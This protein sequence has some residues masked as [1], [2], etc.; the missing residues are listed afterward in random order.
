MPSSRPF[1]SSP[2][3]QQ[4]LAKE[5]ATSLI[6]GHR[7][8]FSDAAS[9]DGVLHLLPPELY[10]LMAAFL[11]AVS[12]AR[13]CLAWPALARLLKEEPHRSAQWRRRA[14]ELTVLP[15]PPAVHPCVMP[16]LTRCIAPHRPTHGMMR[17]SLT[18]FHSRP[19]SNLSSLHPHQPRRPCPIPAIPPSP[20]RMMSSTRSR[21]VRL[22]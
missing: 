4:P 14:Y 21:R 16:L 10:T 6:A 22:A 5:C 18:S 17:A 19:I 15:R 12:V 8:R 3:A 7:R 13:A 11:D 2:R 20:G 1:R 9:L